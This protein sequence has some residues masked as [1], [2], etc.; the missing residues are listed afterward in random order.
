MTAAPAPLDSVFGALA[1]PIR[2]AIVERLLAGGRDADEP[3]AIV[4]KA[5]TPDQRVLVTTLGA[6]VTFCR[7]IDIPPPA[8]VVVGQNVA[9]RESLNW[10]PH[11]SE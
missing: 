2:R 10:L 4:S 1:D 8:L 5:T 11:H 6:V 9:L 3:V 7:S